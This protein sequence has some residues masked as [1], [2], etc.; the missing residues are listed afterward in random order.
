MTMPKPSCLLYADDAKIYREIREPED[1]L[2]LQ[3]TLTEFVSWC[4]RN[5]LSV[6][7]DKCAIISFSRS[8][9]P[10]LFNYTLDGQNLERVNCVKDLGVLLDAKLS[11]EE[12]IDQVVASGNRL[13]GLV[14]NMTRELRDPMCFKTLYCALI[15]PLLEYASIVWWPAST[16]A[17]ARLE[18]IQRKATRFALRDWSRRLDYRT[19]CL[20]L[21]IP[22]LA[23]R[24]EHT[25]LAFI[26]G[27]LNGTIDCPELLSRIH[28]YVPARILRRRPMLAVAETRITFGSRN[29]L[30][31]MCR[32]LNSADDIYEPGMAITE[33]TSLL[34]VRNAFNNN[35][36]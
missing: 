12:Q 5:A 16:R 4:K 3:A 21:G 18:S 31:C 7:I 10:A 28:L 27:I 17:L 30:L 8:R 33:L 24:V 22:H 13:L 32:L 2:Q 34:S 23:E 36:I 15:R 6:C 9:A 11:F 14:I 25:R 1:H 20:L 26:T 29:L 35:N 19:R